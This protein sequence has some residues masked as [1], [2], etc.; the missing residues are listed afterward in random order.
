[1]GV[2]AAWLF[3]A[4][5]ACRDERPER[6][7][8]STPAVTAAV[9]AAPSTL[10]R[11][12]ALGVAPPAE[13]EAQPTRADRGPPLPAVRLPRALDDLPSQRVACF[14]GGVG[15][16]SEEGFEVFGWPRFE[17]LAR[18]PLEGPQNVVELAGNGA[19]VFSLSKTQRYTFGQTKAVDF[20]R[21]P[22]LGPFEVRPDPQDIDSFWVRYLKDP[23]VHEFRLSAP[24]DSPSLPE[25]REL[26]DHDGQ[27]LTWL[28]DGALLYTAGA[29]RLRWS[30]ARDKSFEARVQGER[31][32]LVA[33]RRWDRFWIFEDSGRLQQFEL[34]RGEPRVAV[35]DVGGAPLAWARQDL[36]WVV[37]HGREGVQGLFLSVFERDR[38]RKRFELGLELEAAGAVNARWSACLVPGQ[39]WVWLGTARAAWLVDLQTGARRFERRVTDGEGQ[40]P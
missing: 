4:A 26:A 15:W 10:G 16:L 1:M 21:I 6:E 5:S 39:P 11:G 30:G 38:E 17:R 7:A 25:V 29:R 36:R 27:R 40:P 24:A 32:T 19:L 18:W 31:W 12:G 3:F 20:A 8:P 28:A 33:D 37:L 23:A 13:H 34:S 9:T 14:E 22:V 2:L 35:F